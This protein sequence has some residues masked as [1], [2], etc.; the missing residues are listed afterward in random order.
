M[1]YEAAAA[2]VLAYIDSADHIHP[3]NKQLIRDYHRDMLLA[4]IS[5]AQ[6]QKVLAHFKIET[7]RDTSAANR[8]GTYARQE[9]P[10]R[11][12]IVSPHPR[13]GQ[14]IDK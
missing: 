7:V 2:R 8:V 11:Q 6:Q 5:A 1:D 14:I 12:V 9:P 4:D 10:V 3:E 13:R